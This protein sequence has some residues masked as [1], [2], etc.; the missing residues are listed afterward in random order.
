MG[1]CSWARDRGVDLATDA[2]ALLIH[3]CE[4]HRVIKQ[5]KW[6]MTIFFGGR[7]LACKYGE[8]WRWIISHPTDSPWQSPRAYSDG[9][10]TDGW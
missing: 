8:A 6:L 10:T 5:V 9:T 1:A 7:W 2:I 4:T 3:E